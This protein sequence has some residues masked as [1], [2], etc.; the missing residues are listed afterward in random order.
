[1][2][3]MGLV[4]TVRYWMSSWFRIGRRSGLC[5]FQSIRRSL[6]LWSNV[7]SLL[8]RGFQIG[9]FCRCQPRST[10][11]AWHLK[12]NFPCPKCL[13]IYLISYNTTKTNNSI[14]STCVLICCVVPFAFA[15]TVEITSYAWD[16]NAYLAA[17]IYLLFF[18]FLN[19]SS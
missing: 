17:I 13:N 2:W 16:L 4:T 15:E 1:L 19:P 5:I 7:G 8:E 12:M 6:I 3:I 18:H 14:F 11:C 10:I 9:C